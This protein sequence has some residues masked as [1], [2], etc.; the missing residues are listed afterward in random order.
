MASQVVGGSLKGQQ[1]R[2]IRLSTR[3]LLRCRMTQESIQV[4]SK[5]PRCRTGVFGSL[6]SA[7]LF[8]RYTKSNV[9]FAQSVL[10][11]VPL[12]NLEKFC[13]ENRETQGK[14]TIADEKVN[15]PPARESSS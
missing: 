12:Q 9:R 10:S 14:F 3:P 8:P 1:K 5:W 2:C 13:M 7:D 15:Y 4:M 11:S 6:E